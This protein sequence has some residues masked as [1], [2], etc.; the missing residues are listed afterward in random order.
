MLVSMRYP[1]RHAFL[2]RLAPEERA[3]LAPRLSFV[4]L[5]VGQ[6]LFEAGRPMSAVYFPVTAQVEE[7]LP[8][9]DDTMAVLRRI[10]ADG[11]VGSCVLGD[12]LAARTAR[13]SQAGEAFLMG[14]DDFVRTL[15]EWS[16]FREWVMQDAM[17]ACVSLA[18]I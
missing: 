11:L 5:E 12:P 17:R 9:S 6:L 13:V 14:F 15:E 16:D 7:V 4:T 10:Q 2:D 8:M 1:T 18:Q 3:R